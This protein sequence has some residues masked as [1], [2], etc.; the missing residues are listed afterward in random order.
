MPPR[1]QQ[2]PLDEVYERELEQRFM[3]RV[4]QRLDQVVD[5]LTDRM[6]DLMNRRRPPPENREFDNPFFGNDGSSSEEGYE[7]GPRQERGDGNRRWDAGIH[8]DIPEFDGTSLNSEGFIDWL[9]SVEEVFEFREVPKNK[10]VSLIAT[11]LRGRAS[12]W[13]QQLKMTRNRL[14]KSRIV[15]WTKMKKCLRDT[16]LPHNFQRLMYQRLQNLKQ[17]SRSVDEYTTEFYHLVARNDIQETDEQLVARYI[18]GLR[19]QIMDSVNLFDPLTVTEA[20]QRALAFEKQNRRVGGSYPPAPA[21]G[22]SG[23]GSGG[24]RVVSSQQRSGANN[25]GST[26]KGA[27]SSGVKC[28]KCGETGHRQVDCKQAGKRHLL[29]E[30]EDEQYEEYEKAPEYDEEPEYEEEFVT[31]DVGVNLVVRRSC[32]TPKADGDGWLKHNIFHSTCTILGK[33][34]T[35]V[36]DSGSCDNLISEEAVQKLALKTESHHK[37]YKLQWLKK[38]GEATV[39]KKALVSFS[40]GTTYKDDVVCDVVPMDACHLLLGRPWEYDRSIEHDGQSNS[41]SFMFGGVK[42]TLVP[43]KPKQL[44]TKQSSNLLAISQF[45]DE[46]VGAD[47]VFVLIGKPVPEEVEIPEAMVPLLEEFSDVFPDDLP[48]GL[49]PLRDIQHHVDLEPGSQLP[50]RPHYR[51]SPREHEE[52]RRQVE[53]LIS[54]GHV[55]ESMSPCAVPAL[56]TPKKDGTWRMCVD[57]R[58]INKITVR[59]RFPIPRLDDLLDQISGATIFTKLDLKS[60]YY[61]IRL[62]PGDEWKTAF[63]TREGLYEWLVMPFGL[64]N[65]PS[66]FM[67]VMNQ[68]FR[69][70]IG[71]FVVVYFDDILIYS[72]SFSEHVVHVKKVLAL[73]RRDSFYA[74]TKKCVFM[75]PKVLFLGYVISCDGIQVDE[76]KVAAVQNWPTPTTITEVRSFHGLASFYRRFIPHFSSIMAPMTD[77][78]KGK[79]FVW[80][81]GAELAFQV[82]KEKLTTAPILVLP[83]FSQVFELHTDASKVGIG[84]VLSQGG[85]QIAYFSEKLTGAKL[86]YS[87]YDLEFYAVVQAVKHWRHYLFHKEF[88]LFTDHDSL[89]HIRTQEKISHKHGRWLAF[90]EKFTF[91]VKHKTG[92]S[93]RVA[94][95]L[96]R[97]GN[98]LVSVRINV[99]GLDVIREQLTTDPYF[100]VVLQDVQAGQKSDF[101]LHDGFLF[102][103]NQLCIPDSSLRLKII[104]ELHGEGHVGRDRTLHLVQSSYFW[105]TM[106]KEVDRYVKRCRICQVSK[107]TATNAGLYMPLPVP[108]Q[109]WNDISMDFVLG[110]PQTQR[111]N[112]S[113]FVVV[114]RFS[115]MVHFIPCKKTTDAVNVAQLFFRDVYRLHGLPSSIVSDRDTRFLSHFWRSLWKMVNTQL[116]FSSA[117]HPQ[118]D[119]QTEVV[120]R[121]L[122]NLLRCLVGDHVK[123]WDQKLCQAEFA[124]NHAVN[125]STR[126]SPFQVVYSA[127]PRGPLDLMSLPVPGSVPKKV[128]DFVEG[129]H[130]IHKDVHDNLVRANSKY[131]QVADQKRRHVEFEEG[132]FV[133]AVLTKDRFSV[134]EYNKLS[135]KKIGPVEIVEKINSNAY[136]L[137]LPSHTRCSDVFNVKHL[138]PYY[139]DTSDDEGATDSRSNFFY[140]GGND[141]G[142]SIEDR[143]IMFLEAQ[144]RVTK[145]FPRKRA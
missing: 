139:G 15:T 8:T 85:R 60:G 94:D 6:A 83:D 143:A 28:F 64:S 123:S 2:R 32:Y 110:L 11:R 127:Q 142:P 103:G 3:A 52:L 54:K 58:A 122:G 36:I 113:I 10:R 22:N 34:C 39:S 30:S 56:L 128:K 136:R 1:R 126:F 63:K 141:V 125:R 48:D 99:L 133:W 132:D 75:T 107:G 124:H 29:V 9:V 135:A 130:E 43:S 121:S 102:K 12:A 97:R 79:T 57:S 100:S 145:G 38:G 18:G 81:E 82:I 111:G 105:P 90:L 138:L 66:T 44:A 53:E 45:E 5:Q 80:T 41:Y 98:L 14:R 59:Y 72:A 95:A 67:R 70:F 87:T 42:I 89:R 93:N 76:S 104:Q 74:A 109:P 62:R 16:F 120:N 137:K 92:V 49:P 20:Y 47:N 19:V 35:F 78:I 46:L 40:I 13:W 118:T 7:R 144:D 24:P 114:D 84:G 69:P 119:G 73:L 101:L 23:S 77:C 71:K 25:T 27:S 115:K 61:Q 26:S 108:S 21:G 51:M 50:N 117:Y 17:G 134:G 86:R 106:R 33:V 116:N 91:V 68:L 37:P 140:P 129:L 96:S 31:G 55:R 88:V 4:E 112:D 131:K 65:A